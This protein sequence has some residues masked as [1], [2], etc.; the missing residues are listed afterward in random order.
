MYVLLHFS[1]YNTLTNEV[2]LVIKGMPEIS[3][4]VQTV[5]V[6]NRGCLNLDIYKCKHNVYKFTKGVQAIIIVTS[7]N[8]YYWYSSTRHSVII[9]V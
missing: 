6:E 3:E 2:Y 5:F 1:S 7:I 4:G 8:Y 9:S